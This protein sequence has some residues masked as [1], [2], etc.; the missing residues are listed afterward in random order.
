VSAASQSITGIA[1]AMEQVAR[2]VSKTK[3]AAMVLAR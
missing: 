3:Q 1:S 2:A